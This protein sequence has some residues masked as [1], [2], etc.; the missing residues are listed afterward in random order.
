MLKRGGTKLGIIPKHDI[1]AEG[2]CGHGRS[3][4]V[5]SLIERLGEGA[6]VAQAVEKM[7]CSQ[8]GARQVKEF[9][10]IYVGGSWEALRGAEQGQS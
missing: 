3:V 8:C 2:Q 10:I 1:Y 9:R 7:R 4:S 5:A 6:T